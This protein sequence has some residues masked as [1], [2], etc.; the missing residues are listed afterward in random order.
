MHVWRFIIIL[1]VLEGSAFYD[2]NQI[3]RPCKLKS[4]QLKSLRSQAKVQ[5]GISAARLANKIQVHRTIIGGNLKKMTVK[6]YRREKHLRTGIK[7]KKAI[8]RY[9]KLANQL[10]NKKIINKFFMVKNDNEQRIYTENIKA[11]PNNV[12]YKGVDKFPNKN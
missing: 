12:K 4:G 8:K 2:K 5:I 10:Y 11:T 3:G 1:I 9:R 7:P 6:Y